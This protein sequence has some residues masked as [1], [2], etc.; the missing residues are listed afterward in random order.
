M[1]VLII[2]PPIL[3]DRND[4]SSLIT[5]PPIGYGGV[6]NVI[7]ALINGLI[8]YKIKVTLIGVP[9]S[10][11][12]EGLE[13][14]R[15]PRN[16][17]EIR[18]W[19]Y[20]NKSNF[21]IIHDHSL[22]LVFNRDYSSEIENIPYLAT[23]HKTGTSLYPRNTTYLSNAQRSQANDKESPVIRIP[24]IIDDYLFKTKK[25]EYFLYLGRVSEWKGVYEA[26]MFCKKLMVKL[27]IAGPAWNQEYLKRIEDEFA[28]TIKYMK[29][30]SG[31]KRIDLIAN[32]KAVFVLSRFTKGPWGDSWCEPGSTV[33]SEACASGTPVISSTNGCLSE[34]VVPEVGFQL[35]EDE[36]INVDISKFSMKFPESKQ[37]RK[38]AEINWGHLFIS[39]EYIDLYNKVIKDK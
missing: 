15:E 13:I 21:D 30:T 33:V 23:H 32:A 25:E 14:I 7:Y 31:L 17:N 4:S 18:E 10:R 3:K 19:I 27:I 2:A 20:K 28:D 22:G 6:E 36:I 34:L 35:T 29:D 11:T 26:A 16:A 38:Y 1:R 24:V 8:H 5:I 37:I 39:K 9:G 12:M